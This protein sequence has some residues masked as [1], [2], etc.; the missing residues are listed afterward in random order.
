MPLPLGYSVPSDWTLEIFGSELGTVVNPEIRY[1]DAAGNAVATLA[2]SGT[3]DWAAD[4]TARYRISTEGL[5]PRIRR[6]T[7]SVWADADSHLASGTWFQ[8]SPLDGWAQGGQFPTLRLFDA[9]ARA[10]G[11]LTYTKRHEL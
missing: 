7:T 8:L 5:T 10:P 9:C 4:A 11:V 2:L 1:E 3:L 6:M